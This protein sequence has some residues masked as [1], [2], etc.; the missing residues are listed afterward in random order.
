ME[1]YFDD[2][3]VDAPRLTAE[4]LLAH[5]LNVQRIELYMQFEKP[6]DKDKLDILRG[7][8]KDVG[9]HKPVAYIIGHTEFYSL[10]I[11][12]GQGCL[13]PRPET[14]MLVQRA[15]EFIRERGAVSVLDVCTGS[16]CIAVAI[17]RSCPGVRVL[18]SDVSGKALGIAKSNIELHSLANVELV[19]SDLFERIEGKFDLVVS[20][21]PYI[22]TDEIAKLDR[23]VAEYEPGLAL[24]GGADGLDVY[25]NMSKVLADYLKKDGMVILEIGYDQGASVPKLLEDE[26]FID[27]RAHKDFAGNYRMVTA[28]A[29]MS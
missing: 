5:V 25:R 22:K 11:N 18:A 6:V 7:M 3:D 21:P 12:V 14:E 13:I 27:V 9:N 15:V 26:A 17:G 2:K 1:Q 8:V 19:E 20:N 10:K 4:M 28:I 16:G 23:N 29:P 24:D